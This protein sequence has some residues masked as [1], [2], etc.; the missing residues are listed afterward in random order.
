MTQ[1]KIKAYY[2]MWSEAWKLFRNLLENR[3]TNDNCWEYALKQSESLCSQYE[4]T[5][6][7]QIS[8]KIMMDI[9]EEVQRLEIAERGNE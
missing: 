1:E 4:K 8:K 9:L 2:Q 3:S 6:C 5:E 7:S